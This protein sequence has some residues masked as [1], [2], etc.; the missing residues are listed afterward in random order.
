MVKSVQNGQKSVAQII[1]LFVRKEN[2]KNCEAFYGLTVMN[3]S[4]N[5]YTMQAIYNKM[6]R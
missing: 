5:K 6:H 4:K 3:A 1:Q 2:G